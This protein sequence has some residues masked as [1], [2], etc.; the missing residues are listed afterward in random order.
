MDICIFYTTEDWPLISLKT[1][2]QVSTVI[3][4]IQIT[5]TSDAEW[6][7]FQVVFPT[8]TSK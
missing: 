1:K 5:G 6:S 8:T 4:K 7:N 3:S 2:G